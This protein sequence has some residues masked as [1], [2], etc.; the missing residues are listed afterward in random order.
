[1]PKRSVQAGCLHL[2]SGSDLYNR[3]YR[4]EIVSTGDFSKFDPPLY[5]RSRAR[6]LCHRD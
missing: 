1:M 4:G 5:G 2:W 6:S 3:V